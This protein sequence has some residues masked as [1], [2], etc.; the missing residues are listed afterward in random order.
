MRKHARAARVRVELLAH[1]DHL[2]LTVLDDGRGFKKGRSRESTATEGFGLQGMSE[3]VA[4]I[5]G[6]LSVESKPGRGTRIE[7][8]VPMTGLGVPVRR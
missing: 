4:L 2:H 1:D 5:G 7:V 6:S 8:Q 3:R